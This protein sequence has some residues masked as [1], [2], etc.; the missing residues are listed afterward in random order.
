MFI[1]K[2]DRYGLAYLH[3]VNP[4]LAATGEDVAFT[5]RAKRMNKMIRRTYRGVLMV[6]GGF[7][8]AVRKDGSRTATRT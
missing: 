4:A 3:I 5:E 6:A 8:A 1:E 7:D 2:L